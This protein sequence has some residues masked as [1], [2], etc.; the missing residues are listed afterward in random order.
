M[1]INNIYYSLKPLIPRFLEIMLRRMIVIRKRKRYRNTWPINESAGIRPGGWLGWS[2]KKQF[3][4]VL[5]HDVETAKGQRK[6]LEL[7]KLEQEMG[8]R[9]SFNFVPKR[10]EV[11]MDLRK[12]LVDHG[13]EVGVHGLYHDGKL[14]K[15]KEIFTVRAREIN[16]YL[17]EWNA[18]GFRSPSMHHNLEWLQDLNIEYD[19]STFD[20]DP[21]EPQP[22]GVA[23]I[24]PFWVNV[25]DVKKGY[26]ICPYERKERRYLEKKVGLGC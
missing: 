11:S 15:C 12:H 14:Y 23:T 3:A 21:F 2:E 8:F 9:S 26:V 6:C 4:V 20:T 5:T 24:F 22:D 17:L 19:A 25:N 10:Y 18:A 16:K 7:M 13:F 1:P